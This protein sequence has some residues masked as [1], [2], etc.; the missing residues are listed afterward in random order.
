VTADGKIDGEAAGGADEKA[1][2]A[3]PE[4]ARTAA[5]EADSLLSRRLAA[6]FMTFAWLSRL[7]ISLTAEPS[8][9]LLSRVG[10]VGE[11]PW[12]WW[13]TR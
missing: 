12:R 13:L 4:G 10:S 7:P 6:T 1:V 8:K 2:A 3:W 9:G 5:T 11:G